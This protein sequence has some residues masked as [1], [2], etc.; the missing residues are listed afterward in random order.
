MNLRFKNETSVP[1]EAN[2]G[3]YSKPCQ[4]SKMEVST[5]IVNGFSFLTIFGK[6]PI[7][8]VW[9]DSE[10][11]CKPRKDLREKHHLICLTGS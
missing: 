6:I 2:S 4:T 10:F 1:L 9:H 8:D 11:P 5:K 7:L 3:A